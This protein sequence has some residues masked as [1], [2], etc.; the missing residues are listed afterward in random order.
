MNTGI[1]NESQVRKEDL[2]YPEKPEEFLYTVRRKLASLLLNDLHGEPVRAVDKSLSFGGWIRSVRNQT[3]LTESD[4]AA[5]LDVSEEWIE[6]ISSDDF[7]PWT[8]NKTQMGG[9]LCLFRLHLD[10]LEQFARNSRVADS[11]QAGSP[12]IAEISEPELSSWLNELRAELIG[13]GA[14]DLVT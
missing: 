3:H 2:E 8:I 10:A 11:H 13:R 7:L 5:A 1:A 6:A 14:T 9:L 4:L 12:R